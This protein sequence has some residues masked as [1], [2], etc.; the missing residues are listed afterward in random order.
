M[1]G[2]GLKLRQLSINSIEFPKHSDKTNFD[3]EL[4][5][6]W[7]VSM[8]IGRSN[9]GGLAHPLKRINP[10]I[11]PIRSANFLSDNCVP[12]CPEVVKAISDHN[13]RNEPSYGDDSI[14]EQANTAMRKLFK[15][16]C[17]TFFVGSGVA[18]NALCLAAVC[19]PYRSILCHEHA[20]ANRDEC[21]AIAFFTGGGGLLPCS[22]D[23]FKLTPEGI[24][25]AASSRHGIHCQEPAAV[26]ITQAT[27]AGTVYS[28][29]ELRHLSAVIRE[30][31]L[32][33]HVDGARLANAAA[34]LEVPISEIIAT[35]GA[36][37]VSF[38][39]S[40]NGLHLGE[41][42][43]IFNPALVQGFRFR[44]KQ[45]GHLISKMRFLSAGW[46][47]LLKDD[48]WLANAEKANN[49]AQYLGTQ[50]EKIRG[51]NVVYPCQANFAL[52][53]APPAVI[54]AIVA[55]LR[56]PTDRIMCDGALRFVCSWCT[57][58]DEIDQL[59]TELNGIVSSN[60]VMRPSKWNN[61]AGDS[62]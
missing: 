13:I 26:T 62:A 36:D 11:E 32:F 48:L 53:S 39:G 4:K 59:V 52:I 17:E 21:G 50:L 47:A 33:I 20:H 46:L 10:P 41:A 54:S 49:A 61:A 5:P 15:S 51:I 25:A 1:N 44:I 6:I 19:P 27:E 31:G 43:V 37:I 16:D 55:K 38:G 30:L 3:A 35:V 28:L 7:M 57:S 45:S 42:I 29:E 24:R 14:T 18:A 8:L 12:A 2:I 9:N 22:G 56:W 60:T 40:K 34:Y 23:H 58:S